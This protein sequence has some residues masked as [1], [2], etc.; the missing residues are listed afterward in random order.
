MLTVILVFVAYL[1]LGV[2]T[3]AGISL[4]LRLEILSWEFRVDWPPC[5]FLWWFIVP[6][7]IIVSS[8]NKVSDKV[9]PKLDNF[10]SKIDDLMELIAQKIKGNK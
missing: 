5:V 9:K 2:L 1:T 8:V 6:L 7:I 10:M 3:Y 4:A